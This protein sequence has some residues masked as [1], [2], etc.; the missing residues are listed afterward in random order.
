M[1]LSRRFL[2]PL[3]IA[4]G[5]STL[6]AVAGSSAASSASDSVATSVGSLSG[7]VQ[8]SSNSSSDRDRKVSDGDYRIIELALDPARPGLVRLTLAAVAADPAAPALFLFVPQ[9]VL[10]RSG[11]LEGALVTATQRPYGIE[12]AEGQ[13]RRAFFLALHDEWLRELQSTAVVL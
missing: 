13:P 8:Q 10:V 12:F 6:P 5:G 3:A 9:P 2:I 11:L 7:S 4:L 1:T